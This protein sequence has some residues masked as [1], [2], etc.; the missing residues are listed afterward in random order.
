M[1]PSDR[2]GE[3]RT[4]PACNVECAEGFRF[5]PHCGAAFVA[6]AAQR[7]FRKTVTAIFA[8]LTGSTAIGEQLDPE[9][10]RR[11]MLRYYRAMK[12]VCER[13]GGTVEKFA[14]DAVMAVFGVPQVREDDAM[15]A[16][17]AA[18]EMRERLEEL[19]DELER[20]FGVRLQSRT[21]VNTGEV[22]IRE[23]DPEGT[24]AL[25]DPINV[26]ARLEQAAAPGEILLGEQT[27]RLVRE[28]VRVEAI[29]PLSLKGKSER[30]PG[31]RLLAVLP[32]AEGMARRLETP[33]VGRELELAQ[34]RAACERAVRERTAVLFTILGA[35][36]I[37]KTRLALE[38]AGA[39]AGEM[40][41]L[42]GRC[43]S[44]G[45]GI[46]YWP[47][48]EM[49]REL[50]RTMSLAEALAGES[51]AELIAERIEAAV[52]RAD[53]TG[54]VEETF[55][56]IRQLFE[57]VAR[58]RPLLLVFDDLHW[59]GP[60]LLDLVDQVADLVRDAPLV[61]LCLAR[62]E[63]LDQRPGWGGGK[64]NASSLL[65]SPL[66]GSER[67]TLLDSL[68]RGRDVGQS[69]RARIA[70][71]SDGNPLFLEQMVAML[72]DE[73]AGGEG[74]AIPPAIQAL[75]AARLDRLDPAERCVLECAAIEGE[76]F[77]V[78]GLSELIPT[79]E[80][81]SVDGRLATLVR[82][83]LLRPER[84][85]SEGTTFRFRHGLIREAAYAAVPKERRAELHE[86]FANWLDATRERPGELEEIAGFHFEQAY[87]WRSELGPAGA[88]TL[89]C[90]ERARVRL[91]SAG[92]LALRRGDT[93]AAVNLLERARSLPFSDERGSLEIAPDLGFALFQAGELR[94]AE[95]VLS[96]AIERAGA[97]GERQTELH[98][99]LVRDQLRLFAQPERLDVVSSLRAAEGSLAA[100]QE[101]GDD[102]ALARAWNFIFRLHHCRSEPAPLREAAERALEHARRAGSRLDEASS[103]T[104]FGW[105]LLDGPTPVAEC[106][107]VCE[108]LL[109]ER[110][111]DP[112]GAG[113]VRA[114]LAC[115][116][117]M[118]GRFEEAGVQSALSSAG[119]Q[120]LGR[121]PHDILRGRAETT[122]G[123]YEAAERS[124]RSALERAVAS[125][126]NWLYA[127]ASID[128]ALAL[129]NQDRP[130]ECLH[131][132]D[133]SAQHEAPTD[134]EIVSRPPAVR[135]LALARLGRL[136]E[137][138]PLV[139]QA[140]HS[141]D[142]RHFLG[143]HGDT[144]LVLAEVLR[145]DGRTAEAASALDESL[146][147]FGDKGDVASTARAERMRRLLT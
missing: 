33:V 58:R 46:T 117:A 104:A 15:R 26:A 73:H 127:V 140:L 133:E 111:S 101:T 12:E 98:A 72:A 30:V 123:D 28:A 13:H 2:R 31:Y 9:P 41:V 77:H 53:G 66:S 119:L 18:A 50:T 92:R 132:L 135:A 65:L 91:S 47:V 139:R 126:D 70:E 112:L 86:R 74:I 80:R 37:G 110:Q 121:A 8:D 147:T 97:V 116:L 27:F 142:G 114:F 84:D 128:L 113:T 130:I 129:A 29:E 40:T 89:E 14:G 4:C 105:S 138:A 63:F 108:G 118:D 120:E 93:R 146:R 44:Y 20:D 107:G 102:L 106:I 115:F 45:E 109:G 21:G 23:P 55:W 59:A 68:V 60:T 35:A 71:A 85:G 17:R 62:P 124:A 103:L 22:V 69:A 6:V 134:W 82:R 24:L 38:V 99:S 83:E 19:G 87:R 125:A 16:V 88:R 10:L 1:A 67:D 5:C 25:G 136:G 43:P 64:V 56:A 95:S 81:D 100:F 137:A 144:L 39:V 78:A 79:E 75:L 122:A 131:V 96:E 48:A 76:L 32:H 90:A 11:L 57:A 42:T 34:A 7:V 3:M 61:L 36:G 52:E 49:V 143:F 94:R 145:R 54:L 141:I 51:R